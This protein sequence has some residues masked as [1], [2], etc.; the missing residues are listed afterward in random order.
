LED[1]GAFLQLQRMKGII[2]STNKI[3]NTVM[4]Q[5][6]YIEM[7]EN[8]DTFQMLPTIAT[9]SELKYL[10]SFKRFAFAC[11]CFERGCF[12]RDESFKET[13]TK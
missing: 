5:M 13:I 1:F 8:D 12:C 9:I 7:S 4:P 11:C 3:K 2:A 10:N 6:Y